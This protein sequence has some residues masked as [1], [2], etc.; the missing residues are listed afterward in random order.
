MKDKLSQVREFLLD[1]IESG[2]FPPRSK[3][4]GARDIAA[5]VG[6]SFLLVQHAVS[7]L[8]QDGIVE[9]VSRRGTYVCPG[10]EHRLIRNHMVILK[11][12]IFLPWQK[13][14][15]DLLAEELPELRLAHNF[16]RGMFE[17]RVTLYLQE[18]RDEYLDLS[19]YLPEGIH[20]ET[21]FFQFP[22]RE[23]REPDGRVFGIPF[24][25]SPRVVFYNREMLAQCGLPDP[26][27]DW[28][29]ECFLEYIRKLRQ[30]FCAD[31]VLN[32]SDDTFFWMNFLFRSG[33]K[34]IS[35][36]PDGTYQ[37]CIDSPETIHAITLLQE[38]RRTLQAP[39][40]EEPDAP[41]AS[42]WQGTHA[43]L[44]ADREFY[45][46]GRGRSFNAWGTVPL[47]LLPG[48][49]RLTAQATDLLCVRK[50]CADKNLIRKYIHF[51]LSK[52]VQNYIGSQCYG[53]PIRISSALAS[54]DQSDPRDRIFLEEM[55][56]VSAE[57]NVDS[58]TISTVLH[59]G[60]SRIIASDEP[61]GPAA[62]RLAAA[63]RTVMEALKPEA[64]LKMGNILNSSDYQIHPWRLQ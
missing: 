51:L 30:R 39:G 44:V 49:T 54:I 15:A 35:R 23:F 40:A 10:W 47:P 31:K 45:S 1:G 53:I 62:K 16:Y 57:Y 12:G 42:F 26:A 34:L 55:Q 13:G 58:P 11:K 56:T 61:P 22:F 32:Y 5:E 17:L 59:N 8:E 60:I 18:H 21:I 7:S 4:P 3:L 9:C 19:P 48:G 28:S 6:A 20:D 46:L 27:R 64:D 50:E 52:R 25:F 43:L 2:R 36:R 29:W 14:F 24:I 33:G 41:P 63:I 38:L 37:V